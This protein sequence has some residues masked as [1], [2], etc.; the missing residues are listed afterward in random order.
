MSKFVEKT[1][2][3]GFSAIKKI[4]CALIYLWLGALALALIFVTI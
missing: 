4:I 1:V 3:A 2:D